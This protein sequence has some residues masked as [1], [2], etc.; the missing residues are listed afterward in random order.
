MKQIGNSGHKENFDGKLRIFEGVDR[1]REMGYA[2]LECHD[3]LKL[4]F[5]LS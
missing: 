5:R 1:G 3:N 4:Y 2:V